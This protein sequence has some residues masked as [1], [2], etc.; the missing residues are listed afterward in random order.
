MNEKLYTNTHIFT[1]RDGNTLIKE[2]EGV[3]R[4]NNE[5][6][7]LDAVVGF[8]RASGY[9]ALRPFLNSINK[10]RVLIGKNADKYISRAVSDGLRFFGAEKE[11]K[12][13]VADGMRRDIEG[14]EYRTTKT[15]KSSSSYTES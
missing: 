7:R 11:V 8:M 14:A 12:K 3:L 2:F 1:N 9:F 4:N 15:S 5:I 10:A 13:E 6:C